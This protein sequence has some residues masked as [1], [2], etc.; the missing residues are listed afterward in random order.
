MVQLGLGAPGVDTP[1]TAIDLPAAQEEFLCEW[2][3]KV[4]TGRTKSLVQAHRLIYGETIRFGGVKPVMRFQLVFDGPEIV[5]AGGLM[6][7][8]SAA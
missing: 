2:R 7:G 5:Y 4:I 1:A 3:A 6:V 8:T